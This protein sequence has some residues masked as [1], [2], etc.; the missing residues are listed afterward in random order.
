[1][2]AYVFAKLIS[3]VFFVVSFFIGCAAF[4][5]FCKRLEFKGAFACSLFFA[6][7]ACF[8]FAVAVAQGG[9]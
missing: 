2:D 3:L 5:R 6:V 8:G 9:V 1:M 4:D 7:L